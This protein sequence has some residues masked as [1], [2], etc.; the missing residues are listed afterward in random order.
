MGKKL[1]DRPAY[2]SSDDAKYSL[3]VHRGPLAA[4]NDNGDGEKGNKLEQI[5]S[6]GGLSLATTSR[7]RKEKL[8]RHW[9]RFW[10]CYLIGNVIFLA[11][12][13][14]V[15][16]LVAI[17]AISQL[18]VNKSSLVLVEAAVMQPKPDSIMLTLKSALDLKIALNVR[19]DPLTLDLF[20]RDTGVDNAWGKAGV[21]GTVVK[22]NTTLGTDD[23]PTPLLN[24]TTW[25]D[26]V[27][28]VVFQEKSGLSVKGTTHSYLGVLKS[29][30]TMNKDIISPTLNQFKGFTISDSS[31]I[32]ALD[33]GTN[34]VGNATLPNPS[35]LTLEIGTIVL[36]IKSGNLVIG[37][38]TL[39]NITLKPGNNT[40][41]LTGVLDLTKV[42]KNL[43]EVLTSQASAIREGN[44]ILDTITRTVTWNGTLVPYYT[45]VMSQL[46]LTA[47]V[48]IVGLLKNT[49]HNLV[50]AQNGANFS[51]VIDAM[52]SNS[53][54]PGLLDTLKDELADNSNSS[55][56]NTSSS[57]AS[58]LKQNI[59]VRDAFKDEHPVKRDAL[60]DALAA[61]YLNA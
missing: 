9:K 51:T 57:L 1:D 16:F 26:Y 23:Q 4:V 34:L 49:I 33:D 13:L 41:P 40:F 39:E 17:P 21:P 10:C 28:D 58:E 43:K 27:H 12:F 7:T 29:K 59:H 18:V 31:L 54:S 5:E 60:I 37:N 48:P 24:V 22:G 3:G 20:N 30:V 15:F 36:D 45:D 50:N 6:A 11:I 42:V 61:W 35:V 53:S 38:A 55:S 56:T 2:L 46:T 8:A 19:I 47:K 25:T 14:P 44:L 32:P 52:K